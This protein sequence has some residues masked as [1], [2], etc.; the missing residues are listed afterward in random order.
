MKTIKAYSLVGQDGNAYALMG[1]T[2]NALKKTGY[3]DLINKM[4]T[5]ATTGDYYHL[6]YVCDKY[7]ELCNK[8]LEDRGYELIYD[9]YEEYEG[10]EEE[11][12][13]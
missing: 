5:E 3:R 10:E 9:D 13:Y 1:Y 8:T 12:E 2:A 11:E 7:I 4:H 6:I